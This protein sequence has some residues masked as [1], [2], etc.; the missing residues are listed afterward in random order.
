MPTV[1]ANTVATVT[2]P[3]GYTLSLEAGAGGTLSAP[4]GLFRQLG[5]AQ[6]IGPYE[7]DVN[8]TVSVD[9]TR[10][11]QNYT[12]YRVDGLAITYAPN[13]V[14]TTDTIVLGQSGAP[15][16]ITGTLTETTLATVTVPAKAMGTA[17]A[18]RISALW[19]TT[20]NANNKTLSIRLGGTVI[21]APVI[22]SQ[23]S[24]SEII[25]L[26]NRGVTNSQVTSPSTATTGG[27]GVSTS[28]VTTTA[29]DTT[30]VLALTITA[31][32]ANVADTATLE[33]YSV[34]LLPG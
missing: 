27:I 33:S 10:G 21:S 16:S 4:G 7:A 30:G 1:A 11:A 6:S 15:A 26:R 29:I 19:S 25:T 13:I 2:I 3:A 20:N 32:L 8:A 31:T 18:L 23:A 34:E 17:G 5:I 28:A 9:N 22:A 12:L 14:N 24:F